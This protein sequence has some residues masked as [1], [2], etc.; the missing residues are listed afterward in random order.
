MSYTIITCPHCLAEHVSARITSGAQIPDED[1]E[2]RYFFVAVCRLCGIPAIIVTR[3]TATRIPDGRTLVKH[4]CRTERDPI[5]NFIEPI[6]MIPANG[7]VQTLN[8]LPPNIASAYAEAR[9]CLRRGAAISGAMALKLTIERATRVLRGDAD[10]P[11]VERI[12][13]LV[14]EHN[15]PSALGEWAA[16]IGLLRDEL[17][18]QETD[19]TLADLSSAEHFTETFLTCAFTLPAQISRHRRLA[20]GTGE[21]VADGGLDQQSPAPRPPGQSQAPG[22]AIRGL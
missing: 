3:R 4:V 6:R 10:K 14:A 22:I 15:L 5:P 8:D 19:P 2:T 13:V 1:G 21:A 20:A 16:E 9:D 7:A 17:I 18:N 11:L 12:A